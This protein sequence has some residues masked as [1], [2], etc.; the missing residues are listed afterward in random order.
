MYRISSYDVVWSTGCR[1]SRAPLAVRAVIGS[2]V[3]TPQAVTFMV[4]KHHVCVRVSGQK[5][6]MRCDHLPR[7][8]LIPDNNHIQPCFEH[9][10]RV[11][12]MPSLLGSPPPYP[13]PI[14]V[15]IHSNNRAGE[16]NNSSGE[17]DNEHQPALHPDP[18]RLAPEDAYL[19][20]SLLKA[21]AAN[22]NHGDPLR[23]LRGNQKNSAAAVAALRPLSAVSNAEAGNQ[24]VRGTSRRRK[25]RKGAWKKLLWVKQ[26][27]ID[28][29][30]LYVFLC[31]EMTDVGG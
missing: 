14:P 10:L 4:T 19:A 30:T 28:F 22:A 17:Q 1:L 6:E 5:N 16:S 7:C 2:D 20:S 18:N 11:C 3:E 15:G 9:E 21:R 13:P 27:C 24:K 31:S 12:S 26:S 8:C 29:S 23:T 25:R